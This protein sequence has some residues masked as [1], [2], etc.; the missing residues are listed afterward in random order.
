MNRIPET[1]L[2]LNADGNVYHLNLLP[3][4]VADTVITVGDPERVAAISRHFDHIELKKSKREFFTHTG[5][6]GGKRLTVISTGIGTD[7]IDIVLNEL[8]ALA[9][10]DLQTR[11]PKQQLKSLN[12]IRLGTSGAVQADIPVDSLLVSTAAFGLDTLMHFYQHKSTEQESRLLN[13][14]KEMLPEDINLSPYITS[15]DASLIKNLAHDLQQGITITAPGFYAPQG[16]ELRAKQN[17]SGLM[18][19]IQNFRSANHRITNLE[20]ETAGIYG[21]ASVLE[22]KAISF[23]V[24]LANRATQTFSTQPEKTMDK[25]IQLVLQRLTNIL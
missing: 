20:M 25:Y 3:G 6:I 24:I 22:H 18:D 7:N 9:N 15:A 8:D 23:N 2:I 13:A 21:L 1:E 17:V 12:I 5:T 4:D 16:R 10:I 11:L 14:F 19:I